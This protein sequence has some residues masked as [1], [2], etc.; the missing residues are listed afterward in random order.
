MEQWLFLPEVEQDTP[1][2]PIRNCTVDGAGTYI[3]HVQDAWE[4]FVTGDATAEAVERALDKAKEAVSAIR[5]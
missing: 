5:L 2:S 3:D 4:L 1:Q